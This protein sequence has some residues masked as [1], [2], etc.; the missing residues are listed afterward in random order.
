MR[1][2]MQSVAAG[3]CWLTLALPALGAQPPTS[4]VSDAEPG[5]PVPRAAVMAAAAAAAATHLQV[6]PNAVALREPDARLNP[7]ACASGFQGRPAPGTSS[8]GRVT[9]EV[10]CP[11][12]SWRTFIAARLA[13]SAAAGGAVAP[14]AAGDIG[15]ANGG[16]TRPG[17]SPR[18]TPAV[19][20][21]SP[22][23][24][25][26][27]SATFHVATE[28]IALADAPVGALVR[29]RN[30][31]TGREV[32]GRVIG[33]GQVALA[34]ATPAIQGIPQVAAEAVD[35]TSVGPVARRGDNT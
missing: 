27:G 16:P 31:T 12:T 29:V 7:P 17:P 2:G 5:P 24:L 19:R 30:A 26:A 25:S 6:A 21:G 11:G 22:V 20:R 35:N 13:S 4:A 15:M 8:A 3:L 32:E 1:P 14:K 18:P 23:T 10:S 33:D 34:I 28:G 9:V